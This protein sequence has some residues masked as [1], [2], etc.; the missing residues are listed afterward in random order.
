MNS[1]SNSSCF[2]IIVRILLDTSVINLDAGLLIN[3][4]TCW[5]PVYEIYTSCLLGSHSLATHILPASYMPP[6]F[7]LSLPNTSKSTD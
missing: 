1:G 2:M 6:L 5:I 3:Y 4:M 7:Y